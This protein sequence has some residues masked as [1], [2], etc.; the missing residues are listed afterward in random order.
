MIEVAACKECGSK[1]LSWFAQNTVQNGIQQN[2]LNTNDVVCMF[3]LGCDDCSETLKIISADD[4]AGIM[5]TSTKV[6]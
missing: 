5:N 4:V 2:R 3:V 6:K 1:S